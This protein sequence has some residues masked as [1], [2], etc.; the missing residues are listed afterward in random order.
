MTTTGKPIPEL[1][2]DAQKGD[3]AALARLLSIIERG[4]P[5]AREVGRCVYPHA[6]KGIV[7]GFTGSPGAGKSTL[8]AALCRH[9]R[10]TEQTIGV[11]AVDPSSPFTGGAILGDRIRMGEHTLDSGVFIRSMA[12][13][14]ALGGLSVATPEALRLLDA[15]GKDWVVVETV[16]VGQIE[17]DI[18][19]Q[20]DT[21]VVVVNPGW[22]DA[23]Q[24]N[25]AG[26]TEIADVF[27]V[28]KADRPGAEGTRQD[29]ENMLALSTDKK[30][31][32]PVVLTNA[33]DNE[34][35]DELVAAIAAH[36]KFI[37]DPGIWE[38]ERRKKI[39]NEVES[40][41]LSQLSALARA[42][43]SGP[44]FTEMVDGLLARNTDPWAVATSLTSPDGEGI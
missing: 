33:L 37:R 44:A 1:F 12:T 35:T 40:I 23:V 24:A 15:V 21:T 43:C 16:G 41:V 25:K 7:V 22:G 28:N 39:M 27:V 30:W 18:V 11:L 29:L 26:L 2:S 10:Q 36:Q 32:P 34:G 4:G 13:R 9:L 42:R 20:A 38:E 5:A 3:R 17:I 14:G 6:G 31:V 19:N 8:T